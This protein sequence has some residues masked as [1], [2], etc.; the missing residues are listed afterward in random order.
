MGRTITNSVLII[1]LIYRDCQELSQGRKIWEI[2]WEWNGIQRVR[3]SNPLSSTKDFKGLAE[4]L[5]L[6]YLQKEFL[7]HFYPTFK[8]SHLAFRPPIRENSLSERG[9]VK[10]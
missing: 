3:G 2:L 10:S 9:K 8:L 5:A 4:L 1:S 6:F 7:S